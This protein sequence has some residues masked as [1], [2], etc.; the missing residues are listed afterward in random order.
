MVRH[1]RGWRAGIGLEQ[2]WRVAE[3]ATAA[4]WEPGDGDADD[5]AGSGEYSE[6]ITCSTDCPPTAAASRARPSGQLPRWLLADGAEVLD[7]GASSRHRGLQGPAP[8]LVVA[9]NSLVTPTTDRLD[10]YY[11]A[12]FAPRPE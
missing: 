5:I 2:H 8:A 6:F 9:Y 3:R 10:R 1:G 4:N 7:E 12:V 11:R